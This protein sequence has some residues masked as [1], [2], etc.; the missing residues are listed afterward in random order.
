VALTL[1]GLAKGT[2][3]C[4]AA[5]E[6]D[7]RLFALCDKDAL[8]RLAGWTLLPRHSQ[9]RNELALGLGVPL[10][11]ALRHRQAGNQWC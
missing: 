10:N 1:L 9:Q 11:V 7:M 2:D 3:A 5:H 4:V 6:T 8:A